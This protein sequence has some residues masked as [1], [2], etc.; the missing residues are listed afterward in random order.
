MRKSFAVL[1]TLMIIIC[2]LVCPANAEEYTAFYD[3][4]NGYM[5]NGGQT[6]LT[7]NVGESYMIAIPASVAVGNDLEIRGQ[8]VNLTQGNAIAVH[9]GSEN[10]SG[11]YILLTNDAGE[12]INAKFT[13][14]EGDIMPTGGTIG[15]IYSSGQ[16]V[17]I[18]TG[19]ENTMGAKAGMYTGSVTFSFDIVQG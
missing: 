2:L 4:E 18:H 14:E 15:Y 5:D 16:V 8:E 12:T 6:T 7:Y 1:C 11:N 9:Y 17:T 19:V 3:S 10:M 13:Y